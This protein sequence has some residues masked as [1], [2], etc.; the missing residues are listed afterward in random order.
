M[1]FKHTTRSLR[2]REREQSNMKYHLHFVI[3][4]EVSKS[5]TARLT[6][7]VNAWLSLAR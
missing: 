3:C 4:K 6:Q 7:F 2:E 1:S 5:V